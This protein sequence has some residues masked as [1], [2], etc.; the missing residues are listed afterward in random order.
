MCFGPKIVENGFGR[1]IS[2]PTDSVHSPFSPPRLLYALIARVSLLCR[3]SP[4]SDDDWHGRNPAV[5]RGRTSLL[6]PP[7]HLV[8]VG[9]AVGNV[10]LSSVGPNVVSGDTSSPQP[11]TEGSWHGTSREGM[12]LIC[13]GRCRLLQSLRCFLLKQGSAR[14]GF[15]AFSRLK[16]DSELPDRGKA[17]R[18]F[19]FLAILNLQFWAAAHAMHCHQLVRGDGHSLLGRGAGH[20]TPGRLRRSC[21]TWHSCCWLAVKQAV[22]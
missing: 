7:H 20:P 14:F 11:V 18:R 19:S 4:G 12:Y 3:R 5:L 15:W 17:R 1:Y 16:P 6:L 22:H 21:W 8:V 2:S 9:F 10:L 13:R